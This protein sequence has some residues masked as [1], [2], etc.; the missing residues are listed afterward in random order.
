[1]YDWCIFFKNPL[2]ID[3]SFI[4]EEAS[5]INAISLPA[6]DWE[7]RDCE[8]D[9]GPW[10]ESLPHMYKYTIHGNH[11]FKRIHGKKTKRSANG[12]IRT[13]ACQDTR[14]L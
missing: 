7:G 11:H 13:S 5:Q 8:L 10:H 3:S 9:L 12:S 1:M 14:I 4:G 2:A 6:R